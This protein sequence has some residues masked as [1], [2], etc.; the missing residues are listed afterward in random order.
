MKFICLEKLMKIAIRGIDGSSFLIIN[1]I[2]VITPNGDGKND[3][4]KVEHI[5]YFPGTNLRVYDRWG[6]LIFEQADYDKY[7]KSNGGW[8]PGD[9]ASGTYFYELLIPQVNKK[10]SGYIEILKDGPKN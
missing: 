2:N 8:D 4:F 1:L 3:K 6:K 9:Q 5:E 7:Q 10:E